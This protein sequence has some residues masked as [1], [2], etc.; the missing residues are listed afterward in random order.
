LSTFS[1]YVYY[2]LYGSDN[3]ASPQ[4]GNTKMGEYHCTIDL[5][6]DWFGISCT[7]TYN[8]CFY[9][10]NRLIQTSQIGGQQYNDTSPFSIPCRKYP[11]LNAENHVTLL[12]VPIV[13]GIAATVTLCSAKKQGIDQECPPFPFWILWEK[14]NHYCIISCSLLNFTLV[15][16]VNSNK[17]FKKT[18]TWMN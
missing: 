11:V 1:L 8:F 10:Q 17:K 2:D 12:L 18:K 6:F 7:A 9:F 13:M 14:S 4:T 5:L 15:Y 3:H 16:W